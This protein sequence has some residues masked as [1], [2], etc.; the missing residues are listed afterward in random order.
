M[1]DSPVR[2]PFYRQSY[3]VEALVKRRARICQSVGPGKIVVLAGNTSTGA[4]DYFRQFND[5]YYLTGIEVPHAYF[6][7]DTTSGES[8]L[9]LPELDSKMERSEGAMLS[10]D[11]ETRVQQLT[12]VT[13]VKGRGE[14]AEDLKLHG[15]ITISSLYGE[16]PQVCQDVVRHQVHSFDDDP[17]REFK[18]TADIL[19]DVAIRWGIELDDSVDLGNVL[20]DC[21]ALKDKEEQDWM[22]LAGRVTAEAVNQAMQSTA[23]GVKEYEL[24]AIANAVFAVNGAIGPGYRAIVA[25]GDN[26]WNAHYFR[27]GKEL[28]A[29]EHVLM[30]FAPDV[31][32]Y[33]S[34][35]GRIWPVDGVYDD[36]HRELYGFIVEYHKVL[37]RHILPGLMPLKVMENAAEEV[38]PIID[39]WSWSEPAFKQGAIDTLTFKGHLSHMVGMAVHDYGEYHDRP[40]EPGCVFAL[41]PQMWINSHRLY[42]RVEDTVCVTESGIE[43]YTEDCPLELDDVEALMKEEGVLGKIPKVIC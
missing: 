16:S 2:I 34:D 13:H 38:R 33:T 18:S 39:D 25:A 3:S 9:Y 43:T 4:F 30:D 17:V 36:L 19:G 12:G 40:L 10:T 8:T 7:L 28:E 35:I 5:F 41:D 21:R 26:I 22:R 42:I 14:L 29:G 1:L 6:S 32:Y 11:D 31:H 23:R 15:R 20:T 27:N 37:K 24:A